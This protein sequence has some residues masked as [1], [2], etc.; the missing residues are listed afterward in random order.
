VRAHSGEFG[1]GATTD[2][3]Y[4]RWNNAPDIVR[5]G[6]ALR[7]GQ[8]VLSLE[9]YANDAIPR[10]QEDALD[11][12]TPVYVSLETVVATV[13]GPLQESEANRYSVPHH[14][15]MRPG[16]HSAP[17]WYPFFRSL[18]ESVYA[19]MSHWDGTGNVFPDPDDFDY[20]SIHKDFSIW[21]WQFSVDRVPEE[22]LNLTHVT[23]DG[24]TLRGSG[25]VTVTVPSKC[26]T[27]VDGSRVFSVDLG[28][29]GVTNELGGT[30]ACSF[31]GNQT[32]VAL[33]DLPEPGGALSLAAGVALLFG[34][35]RGCPCRGADH[36]LDTRAAPARPRPPR[37]KTPDSPSMKRCL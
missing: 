15:E 24:I 12:L 9:F 8:P 33:E 13:S 3:V 37:A 22:F 6:R 1:D 35:R 14:Y 34:L 26:G 31:V 17:Y 23:C 16:I 11:P 25:V 10:R 30:G 2:D 20:R 29:S 7:N 19:S 36:A 5:N 32:A 21:G 27:G 4:H 28:P 18:H